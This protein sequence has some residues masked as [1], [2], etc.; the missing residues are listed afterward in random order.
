M[1]LV[2]GSVRAVV[3]LGAA[4]AF[5]EQIVSALSQSGT[6]PIIAV[7]QPGTG[8]RGHARRASSPIGI[9]NSGQARRHQT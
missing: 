2:P 8:H 6:V 7:A 9:A 1:R 5:G 4:G 3:V